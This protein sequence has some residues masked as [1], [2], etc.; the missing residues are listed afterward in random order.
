MD[1]QLPTTRRRLPGYYNLVH[2]LRIHRI[3][4]NFFAATWK[5][6]DFKGHVDKLR[7]RSFKHEFCVKMHSRKSNNSCQ[8]GGT[9]QFLDKFKVKSVAGDRPV[10]K[11]KVAALTLAYHH[12]NDFEDWTSTLEE[13]ETLYLER[14]LP[15]KR[16]AKPNEAPLATLLRIISDVSNE[17]DHS[18]RVAKPKNRKQE[19]EPDH[20]TEISAWDRPEPSSPPLLSAD[21]PLR[22]AK[23]K[24]RKESELDD[25]SETSPRDRPDPSAAASQTSIDVGPSEPHQRV[26][27]ALPPWSF[28]A[29][30]PTYAPS[31]AVS[32]AHAS[33]SVQLADDALLQSIPENNR[34]Y[35]FSLRTARGKP[36]WVHRVSLTNNLLHEGLATHV[37]ILLAFSARFRRFGSLE[38]PPQYETVRLLWPQALQHF[39]S[40]HELPASVLAHLQLLVEDF[41]KDRAKTIN[42]MPG[43]ESSE[44][45]RGALRQAK[46]VPIV[47]RIVMDSIINRTLLTAPQEVHLLPVAANS[48]YYFLLSPFF[49]EH[50]GFAASVALSSAVT[51]LNA[52]LGGQPTSSSILLPPLPGTA[53]QPA[54][55]GP[56]CGTFV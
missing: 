40:P 6:R 48:D 9:R 42:S 50:F 34:P 23:L 25:G 2:L 14:I 22:P 55:D 4:S 46:E 51:S 31:V 7:Q 1:H 56:S 49:E 13:S 20:N 11:E 28:A 45:A 21:H 15:L 35:L 54:A 3:W 44:L 10:L 16:L 12:R 38:R 53:S 26:R 41:F 36:E 39:R 37:G 27:I 5:L 30:A 19:S 29:Q 52:A 47:F 43:F 33:R 32:S 18:L 24:K 8:D 17:P